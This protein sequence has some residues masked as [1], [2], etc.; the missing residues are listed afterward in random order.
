M[1]Y[2]LKPISDAINQ[3]FKMVWTLMTS[4]S[5]LQCLN[6]NVIFWIL[7]LKWLHVS[8]QYWNK[9]N[10]LAIHYV[11]QYLHDVTKYAYCLEIHTLCW[12]RDLFAKPPQAQCPLKNPDKDIFV[13]KGA[14]LMMKR[15]KSN[16]SD[17][18]FFVH[19]LSVVWRNWGDTIPRQRHELF[20][21]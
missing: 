18:T 1:C 20:Q 21:A 15:E 19:F 17:S 6:C 3:N 12:P 4:W 8:T 10:F 16:E 2:Q 7:I 9:W 11:I 13:E 14:M 5:K